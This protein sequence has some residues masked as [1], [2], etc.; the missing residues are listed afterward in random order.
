MIWNENVDDVNDGDDDGNLCM[1]YDYYMLYQE[2]PFKTS[3]FFFFLI[4]QRGFFR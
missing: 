2:I 4:Q 3:F 1:I